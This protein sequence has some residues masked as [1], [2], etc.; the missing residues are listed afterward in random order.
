MTVLIVGD[1][2]ETDIQG[3]LGSSQISRAKD[4]LKERRLVAEKYYKHLN[5]L[6]WLDMPFK[7]EDY[8]HSFQSFPC[9]YKPKEINIDSILDVNRKRN[10]WMETLNNDGIST[11]PATHA[12]HTLS[13][14]SKKYNLK[15]KDFFNSWA[16][17]LCSISFPLFNGMKKNEIEYVVNRINEHK[18]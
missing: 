9:L 13:Y 5:T 8:V 3:A 12:V 17:S 7:H 1:T 4:I 10:N 11:R 15:P 2:L 18:I 14:Y 16:A 6:K